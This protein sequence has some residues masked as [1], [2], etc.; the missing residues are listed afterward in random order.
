VIV[1][2]FAGGGGVSIALERACKRPVDVAIN[3]NPIALAV[4]KANH[5]RTRHLVTDIYSPEAEPKRVCG[6][7]HVSDLWA[8][9]DCTHHSNARGGKPIE[10]DTRFL[11][12]VILDWARIKRPDRIFMENVPEFLSWGPLFLSGPRKGEKDPSRAGETFDQFV[13]QLELLGYKVEWRIQFACDYGAPTR[14]R[15]LF[16][17]A[18]CDGEPIVWP[19]PTHGPGRLPYRTA[20]ECIDWSIPGRSIFGRKR[21]LAENTMWRIAQG[22]RRFVF[23]TDDPFIIEVPTGLVAPVLQHSGNGERP[24]Q[25]ARVYDLK[26][27]LGTIMATGQKHAL[28]MAYL[29][30]YFGD[31]HR[32]MGGG[33]VTGSDLREPIGTITARDHHALAAVTLAHLRGGV[34]DHPGCAD[35]RQPMPTITASG[36]H[37][38]QVMAFLT[39]YYSQDHAPGHGQSLNQPLRT[40]TT[41]Q[42]LGLVTVRGQ[43]YQITDIT[44]R[45]LKAPELLRGQF[46][47]YAAGY[48]LS[49]AKTQE[50]QV[51]LIGN[52]VSP[53]HAEKII[54][55][56]QPRQLRRAA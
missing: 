18:R 56:N 6:S 53:E 36:T 9:P 15:R 43:D 16:L 2:L 19:E 52:S 47:Q 41:R 17:I 20:A 29:A 51:L 40:I 5:P 1:D 14:R 11:A 23:E 30:K 38:A 8:S 12:W 55:A 27:P 31:P 46:G 25:R 28:V 35:V 4:H 26:E 39:A 48:D 33:I 13:G 54:A 7:R 10:K 21:P 49:A 44:L 22:L 32:K 24:T 50:D 45:M 37:V 34:A 3:H 42:R